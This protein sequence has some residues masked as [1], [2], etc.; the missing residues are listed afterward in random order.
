MAKFES[1]FPSCSMLFGSRVWTWTHFYLLQHRVCYR[2]HPS[3]LEI[4]WSF[5][6]NFNS[7]SMRPSGLI[8]AH[9]GQYE[10]SQL[11]SGGTES[12]F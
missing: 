3:P 1:Q 6:N 11:S 9:L 10:D 5:D 2:A 4:N 12:S 7:N 8:W